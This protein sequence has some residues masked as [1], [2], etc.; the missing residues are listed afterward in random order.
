MNTIPITGL[1]AVLVDLEMAE[2][3]YE[4]IDVERS[5]FSLTR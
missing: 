1:S 5:A 4:E 2:E 3:T